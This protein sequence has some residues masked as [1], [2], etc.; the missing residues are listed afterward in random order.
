MTASRF[1]TYI[2]TCS[3]TKDRLQKL[4]PSLKLLVGDKEIVD[5]FDITGLPL[6]LYS[7]YTW[8]ESIQDIMHILTENLR[9]LSC[10]D[11]NIREFEHYSL[12]PRTLKKSERSLSAK[13]L[14]S[15]NRFLISGRDYCV[16][17]EDDLSLTKEYSTSNIS[18]GYI[19]NKILIEAQ[20]MKADFADLGSLP[21]FDD[22]FIDRHI[23]S[24]SNRSSLFIQTKF[25]MTRSTCCF[26]LSSRLAASIMSQELIHS[27][28]IDYHL[29][30]L[31][32]RCIKENL[33]EIRSFWLR[34]GIFENGSMS[35]KSDVKTSIQ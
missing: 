33:D 11:E 14:W 6:S 32:L 16:I 1:Y 3:Q 24:A 19:L 29:Q 30:L 34:P 12:M 5:S 17:M 21:I 25:P 20:E 2:I 9:A 15:I 7:P 23:F 8:T 13:I 27:M 18:L 28:P 26:V 22:N 4:L 10:S 35:I 31:F